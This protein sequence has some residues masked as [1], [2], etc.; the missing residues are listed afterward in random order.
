MDDKR[1]T[2][3]ALYIAKALG[4]KGYATEGTV[5]DENAYLRELQERA[6][7]MNQPVQP[8]QPQT[9]QP[10][11]VTDYLRQGREKLE[12]FSP[13]RIGEAVGRG[14]SEGVQKYFDRPY[15]YTEQERQNYPRF[16]AV[17]EEYVPYVQR[18]GRQFMY[19][20]HAIVPGVQ[21]GV[22]QAVGQFGGNPDLARQIGR[23]AGAM[24]EWGMSRGDIVSPRAPSNVDAIPRGGEVLPP[25]RV[26]AEQPAR[27]PT[28][29]D[30][31]TDVTQGER[32]ALPEPQRA[33]PAPQPEAVVPQEVAPQPQPKPQKQPKPP[34]PEPVREMNP[35]GF[36]SRGLEVSSTL[37]PK[38]SYDQFY[39]A[40]RSVPKP[41]L[42][43][44]KAE[45]EGRPSITREE[46]MDFFR[47]NAPRIEETVYGIPPDV[48]Y[49][50]NELQAEESVCKFSKNLE[51]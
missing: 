51:I 10:A 1:S 32:P 44:F 3:N 45:F 27:R 17:T 41:E 26:T 14:A 23:E 16:T 50:I 6:T 12:S 9:V 47:Q 8:Q 7:Q 24:T 13:F 37:Q 43:A 40:M 39:G 28:V 34:A 31:A 21:E 35:L 29:I 42:E 5:E 38:G 33:L 22:T 4:R 46:V 18:L 49:R 15:G 2:V 11:T 48:Q 20:F 25:A 36:Y 30:Q 19:P